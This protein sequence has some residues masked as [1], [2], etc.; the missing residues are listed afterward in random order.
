MPNVPNVHN[1]SDLV[2]IKRAVADA[3]EEKAR[4]AGALDE[5][6][7]QLKKEFGC[8][9]LEEA[10]AKLKQLTEEA[11]E[12]EETFTVELAAF[13]KEYEGIL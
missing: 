5:V 7:K 8:K 1:V 2:N 10:E 4:A 12:A 13:K 11:E 9:T 6:M 3:L